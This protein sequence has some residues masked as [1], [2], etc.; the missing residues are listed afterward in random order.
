[1]AVAEYAVIVLLGLVCFL[2]VHHWKRS[3]NSPITNWPVVGMVPGLLRN[4][5][6]VFECT[7]RVL[8][9]YG[10]TVE[11]KGLWFAGMDFII[12]SDPMNVNH[13][14]SKNFVS[15]E[16]GSEIREILEPLGDGLINS[17]S[18]W[19]AYQ[20]KMMH[21]LIKNSKFELFLEKVVR[22]KAVNGLIPVLDHVSEAEI[23]V[24]L[25]EIFKRFT[26]DN[27]CL[28]VLG[29]DP[30]SLSVDFPKRTYAKAF[31]EIEEATLYRHILPKWCWKLQRWLQLGQEKKLRK[32]WETFD[33]FLYH[34]ISSKR[35]ELSRCNRTQLEE[36]GE[37]DLLT[38]YIM[39]AEK[40]DMGGGFGESNKF[41]RDTV[42]NLMA[43]GSDTMGKL[44]NRKRCNLII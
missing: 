20:R 17:D 12:T 5:S 10:G 15:Y 41:L 42:M 32:A 35:E 39:Q 30:T 9:H 28:M 23:E 24:D 26:F 22:Q 37:F 4:A 1:M 14:L 36:E 3:K 40:G 33:G 19:W 27:S 21:S 13:I 31:D 25:Q 18:D 8:K 38:A 43:A 44:I 34:C 16:K 29:F 11:V 6:N 2:F 7:N